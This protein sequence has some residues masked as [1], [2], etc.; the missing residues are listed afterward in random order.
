MQ[1]YLSARFYRQR[2][3]RRVRAAIEATGHHRVVSAWLDQ[4]GPEPTTRSERRRIAER[5]LRDVASSQLVVAELRGRPRG[6]RECEV[7]AALALQKTLWTVGGT[8]HGNV[9]FALSARRFESW[10]DVLRALGHKMVICKSTR[11]TRTPRRSPT[12]SR[13][14]SA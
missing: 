12:C 1:I 5:D 4:T 8:D 3:L 10:Q 11:P 13:V 7:G 2:Q 6:G 9:F 14:R